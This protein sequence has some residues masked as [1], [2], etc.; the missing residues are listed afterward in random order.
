M[1]IADADD[2][3]DKYDLCI[4]VASRSDVI[5]RS[6]LLFAPQPKAAD[7]VSNKFPIKMCLQFILTCTRIVWKQPINRSA[8]ISK[9]WVPIQSNGW[10]CWSLIFDGMYS[11]IYIRP[12]RGDSMLLGDMSMKMMMMMMMQIMPGDNK[13]LRA[14]RVRRQMMESVA[15]RWSATLWAIQ[16]FRGFPTTTTVHIYCDIT[17]TTLPDRIFKSQL[18]KQPL[19]PLCHWTPGRQ[20]L[21]GYYTGREYSKSTFTTD[22]QLLQLWHL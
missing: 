6:A 4:L 3:D 8:H 5:P 1:D 13:V 21:S 18:T 16:W 22:V 7:A 2:R 12:H 19:I 11:T 20:Y 9:S 17:P 10:H 14:Q 15:S